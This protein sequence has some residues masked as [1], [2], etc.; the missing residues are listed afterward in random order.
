MTTEPVFSK[1]VLVI[2]AD[3]FNSSRI[4]T[5]LVAAITS[6]L[7]IAETPGNVRLTRRQSNLTRESVANVS[8]VIT[9]DRGFLG[10]KVGQITQA[11]MNKVNAGL[12][13]ALAL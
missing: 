9:L 10:E 1:P 6:N 4:G 7:H 11:Q 5:I 3:L 2:Q 13:L 12:R 8:Q